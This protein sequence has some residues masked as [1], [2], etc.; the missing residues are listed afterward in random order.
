[1]SV[2]VTAGSRW[3]RGPSDSLIKH[4]GVLAP[5]DA[6]NRR[7]E[8]C[9]ECYVA[10]S[11]THRIAC[12]FG[13]GAASAQDVTAM[14]GPVI[15]RVIVVDTRD[16]SQR[17]DREERQGSAAVV[18]GTAGTIDASDK[19]IVP[20]YLDMHAHVVD[21][22]DREVAFLIGNRGRYGRAYGST[23]ARCGAAASRRL[24]STA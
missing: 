5:G 2:T 17:Q 8:A 22:S 18:A 3:M 16:G 13:S 14:T 19:Y 12:Y 6:L 20:G 15:N 24:R 1:M 4:E 11:K 23:R 10:F 7:L 21:A 9:A